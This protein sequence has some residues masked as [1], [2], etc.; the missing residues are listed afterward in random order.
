MSNS[1]CFSSFQKMIQKFSSE[2]WIFT[3]IQLFLM[4]R[5]IFISLCDFLYF[6]TI[7]FSYCSWSFVLNNIF[8]PSE[9]TLLP[10][11]PI[12]LSHKGSEWWKKMGKMFFLHKNLTF[13]QSFQW[14]D[15]CDDGVC[16][17]VMLMLPGRHRQV[18]VYQL[19]WYWY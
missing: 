10:L 15:I 9:W 6:Q 14:S 17:D 11:W 8:T 2:C 7:S 5:S 1:I 4:P 18:S 16:V 3:A 13:P 12:H 19:R